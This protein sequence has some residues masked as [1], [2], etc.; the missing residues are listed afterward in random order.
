MKKK[1]TFPDLNKD[2]KITYAEIFKGRDIEEGECKKEKT[3]RKK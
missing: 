1:K 2:G 3:T